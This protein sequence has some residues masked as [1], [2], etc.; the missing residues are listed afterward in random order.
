M[1]VR[2]SKEDDKQR[3]REAGAQYCLAQEPKASREGKMVVRTKIT[4]TGKGKLKEKRR[5]RW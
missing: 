4:V 2:V 3:T 1:G 5:Q